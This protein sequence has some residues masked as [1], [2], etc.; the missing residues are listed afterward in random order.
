[1]LEIQCCARFTCQAL[2]KA[3]GA[4]GKRYPAAFFDH[5]IL[6]L[7]AG[8][9]LSAPQRLA[10]VKLM[11]EC[12][13]NDAAHENLVR[14]AEGIEVAGLSQAMDAVRVRPP[15]PVCFKSPTPLADGFRLAR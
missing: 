10:I 8:S 2:D 1:M 6:P 11:A 5:V 7:A 12:F 14:L 4:L 9:S 13:G 15:S 3:L